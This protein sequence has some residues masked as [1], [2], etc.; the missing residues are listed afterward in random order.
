MKPITVEDMASAILTA[1]DIC[2]QEG[3]DIRSLIR[4]AKKEMRANVTK[5]FQHEGRVVSR[6]TMIDWGTRQRA[7]MDLHKLR[8]DYPAE[9]HDVDV[10]QP[11]NV[12]IRKFSDE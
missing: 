3:L 4:E 1:R 5:F 8:G 11:I 2:E 9:K 12:I 10:K 6:R 7:R